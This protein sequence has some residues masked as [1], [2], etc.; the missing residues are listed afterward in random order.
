MR[1]DDILNRHGLTRDTAARYIEA[2]THLNQTETADDLG[3]SRDTIAR[4]KNSF[5]DMSEPERMHLIAALL[6]E[7]LLER[8]ASD[9]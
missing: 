5:G 1:A 4:Y 8:S 9:P 3:V 6:Q 2:I 7:R